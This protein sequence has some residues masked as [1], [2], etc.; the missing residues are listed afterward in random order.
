MRVPFEPS[1]FLLICC[2][3][4]C[5]SC[6]LSYLLCVGFRWAGYFSFEIR[7]RCLAA[8]LFGLIWCF[9]GVPGVRGSLLFWSLSYGGPITFDSKSGV[10]SLDQVGFGLFYGVSFGRSEVEKWWKLN[11]LSDMSFSDVAQLW[12]WG[13]GV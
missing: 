9:S 12:C 3:H 4:H 2:L 1:L 10:S 6:H 5:I 7:S 11:D 13:L 8:I